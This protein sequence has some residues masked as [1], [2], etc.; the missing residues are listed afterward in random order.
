[1]GYIW[2]IFKRV[3][4]QGYVSIWVDIRTFKLR[5]NE[6]MLHGILYFV[7]WGVWDNGWLL[8]VI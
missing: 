2:I 6:S 7:V 5:G 4:S 8:E 3:L 1:M